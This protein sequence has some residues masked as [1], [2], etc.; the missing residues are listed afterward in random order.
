MWCSGWQTS[1][2][3]YAVLLGNGFGLGAVHLLDSCLPGVVMKQFSEVHLGALL[4][5]WSTEFITIKESF[6]RAVLRLAKQ[7]LNV[8]PS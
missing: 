7:K 1:G 4:W 8:T 3:G 2:C 5:N 6:F